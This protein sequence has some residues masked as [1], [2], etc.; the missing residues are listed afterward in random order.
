MKDKELEHIPQ[1]LLVEHLEL[2]ERLAELEEKESIQTNFLPF[3]K[4]M[5]SEFIESE[6][7]RIMASAFD[8]T[9]SLHSLLVKIL[10]LKLYRQ[11][12]QQT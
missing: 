10:D 8:R 11:H 6:H 4:S 5:W 2:S 9:S 3:V 1:E 7:H 12:T